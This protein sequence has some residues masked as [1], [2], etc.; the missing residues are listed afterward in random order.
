M[1]PLDGQQTSSGTGSQLSS[2]Q[3]AASQSAYFDLWSRA[4]P[5]SPRTNCLSLSL[6]GLLHSQKKKCL[7]PPRWFASIRTRRSRDCLSGQTVCFSPDTKSGCPAR[8]NNLASRLHRR[9]ADVWKLG[10][11]RVV[12]RGF[13]CAVRRV[14]ARQFHN[15][16]QLQSRFG[17]TGNV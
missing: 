10:A 4:N 11:N 16:F 13:F 3:G 5:S 8:S 1:I 6:N 2:D 14:V 15:F 17:N 7:R 12:S 9:S